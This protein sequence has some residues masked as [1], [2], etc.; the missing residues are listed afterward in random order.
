[1]DNQVKTNFFDTD[2][3]LSFYVQNISGGDVILSDLGITVPYL[4]ASDL[5]ESHT[6]ERLKA[7][8]GLREAM[9]SKAGFLKKVSPD[10][11]L[12]LVDLQK[13]REGRITA[14]RKEIVENDQKKALALAD[15]KGN[16]KEARVEISYKVQSMVEKLK[17]FYRGKTSALTPEDFLV[18]IQNTKLTD[19][20]K[21]YI[22][23]FA[24]EDKIRKAII[25]QT[26]AEIKK[27]ATA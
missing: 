27:I 14:Q 17:L 19:D 26:E 1:M 9:S 7:S 16:V 25:A 20:E 15:D 11:Y 5:R 18:F 21:T 10:E 12:Q 2:G 4:G 22:L 6:V 13:K 23:G 8:P 3:E 24:K